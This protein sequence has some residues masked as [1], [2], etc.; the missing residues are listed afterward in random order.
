MINSW[1]CYQ[2]VVC[3]FGIILSDMVN[4]AIVLVFLVAMLLGMGIYQNLPGRG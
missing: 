3:G 4:P 1:H 2:Q